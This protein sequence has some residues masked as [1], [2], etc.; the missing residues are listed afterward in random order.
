MDFQNWVRMETL[1]CHFQKHKHPFT[2]NVL[3]LDILS[4]NTVFWFR[5]SP[6][7]LCYDRGLRHAQDGDTL[8]LL[9]KLFPSLLLPVSRVGIK[10][11]HFNHILHIIP[12]SLTS[13]TL[14]NDYKKIRQK[15]SNLMKIQL[16]LMRPIQ[17]AEGYW[18][19]QPR[20]LL[21]QTVCF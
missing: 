16:K 5:D 11:C 3:S 17:P 7:S 15:N 21:Q 13:L 4:P 18:Q 9:L 12:L 8:F 6:I 19:T 20:V 10:P 1:F 14:V 2:L